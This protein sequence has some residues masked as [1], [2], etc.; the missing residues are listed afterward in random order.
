MFAW[1]Q[2][3]DFLGGRGVLGI[4]QFSPDQGGPYKSRPGAHLP[5]MFLDRQGTNLPSC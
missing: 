1:S 5:S 3:T 2:N 4:E